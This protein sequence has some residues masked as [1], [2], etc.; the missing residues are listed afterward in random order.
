MSK[1]SNQDKQ[2]I[3]AGIKSGRSAAEL[4]TKYKISESYVYQ[5]FRESMSGGEH[6]LLKRNKQLETRLAQA[7]QL[8]GELSTELKKTTKKQ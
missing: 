6:R 8:I 2:A 7:Y 5:L 4:A 1:L 3:I